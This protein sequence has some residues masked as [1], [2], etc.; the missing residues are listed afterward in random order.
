MRP[1]KSPP[2]KDF[3]RITAWRLGVSLVDTYEIKRID[4]DYFTED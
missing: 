1:S 3:L 4:S 2:D